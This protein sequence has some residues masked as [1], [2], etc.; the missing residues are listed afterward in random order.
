[1]NAYAGSGNAMVP[2]ADGPHAGKLGHFPKGTYPL[3]SVGLRNPSVP[4]R[5]EPFRDF[6]SVWHD[7]PAAAQ[8]FNGFFETDP[9]FRYVLSGVRDAFM[10]N[11][12]S[13]SIGPEII[14]NR[15]GVGPMHDCLSCAFE[16][17][18]LSSFTVG[19]PAQLTDVAANFGGLEN[20]LPGQTPPPGATG[21][22]ANFV[23]YPADP[24]N[25]HHSYT[26]DFV[27][28][29]NTHVGKEQHV[30]H[31]HNH[32]WLFNAN[33]DNSN[34]LDAQ[35][36]GP[37]VGYTYEIAFGGSGN[38]NKT[39]GDAIFHCHFYPHFAQGMWYLWRN[40][41]VLETG[42]R[43]AV[44]GGPDGFHSAPFALENGTPALA[45]NPTVAGARVRALPDGEVVAGAPIP[46]VVPLPGKPMA[47]LPGEVQTVP[48]PL[49]V[50]AGV[51]NMGEDADLNAAGVQVPVGSL[52]RVVEREVNPGYPFWIAGI[53]DT[54]GQRAT[55][56][57]LDMAGDAEVAAAKAADPV[58]FANLDP[59]QADGFDGGLPRATLQGVA[60]GGV[61]VT[62][63]GGVTRLDFSKV[64]EE[65]Q[66]VFFP[67]HGTDVERTAMAFHAQ[68]C[69]D[70][71]LP[72]GTPAV[73]TEDGI[74]DT[75][76]GATGGFIVNGQKPAIGAPYD[77][78]CID[79]Q[80]VRLS[81]GVVGKFFGAE[82][83][84]TRGR[85]V[86][87]AD[88]PRIYKGVSLQFDA[89][90]NKVGYHYPQ[91]RVFALWQDAVP[92][93]TKQQAPEPFVLRNNTFDCTVYHH[94][95]LIPEVYEVDD[96]QVRTPT[97]IVGQHVHLP[98][99]DL[100][101]A[102]GAANGWN[103][104]DGTLSPGMVRERIHALN[105]F[106]N[107][108]GGAHRTGQGAPQGFMVPA[109]FAAGNAEAKLHPF[110][111][112]TVEDVQ[113]GTWLGA[114]TTQQRWFFDPVVNTEGYDR[115]LGIIFTHDH[116][117]PSTHQQIGLYGTLLTEP[118]G[119]TWVHNETGEQLGQDP[120]TGAQRAGRF[121]GGPTSWQAA[122]LPP[123]DEPSGSSVQAASIEPFRE[124]FFEYADFQHAYE[125]GVY[126]GADQRGVATGDFDPETRETIV[127]VGDPADNA[128]NPDFSGM[129][130][131]A[132]RFSINP[133]GRE[134][135][136]PVF[137]D[138][139]LEAAGGILPGCPQRPCPQAIDV[140]DPGMFVV[141]YRNEPLGLRVFDP[142]RPDCPGEGGCQTLGDA[143]DLA[144]AFQSRRDR[145]I[146]ALNVQPGLGDTINGTRFPPALSVSADV[147][148]GDP[149]TPMARANVGDLVRFKQEAGAH[150]EEHTAMIHGVKWLQGGSGHGRAPNSGWR[151]AQA[152]GIAEQFTLEV[153]VITAV[154]ALDGDVDY[155]YSLD[156]AMDGYWS[157]A[158][159]ILRAYNQPRNDL[160]PLPNGLDLPVQ[161]ANGDEFAGICPRAATG[162]GNQREVANLRRYDVTA[163]LA[164]D[165]LPNVVTVN[166]ICDPTTASVD[167]GMNCAG[168][169]FLGRAPDPAGGTLVYNPRGDAV[170]GA[171]DASF[172]GPLHDPTAVLWFHT[173]DL[174]HDANGVPNG[175]Q[176][177]TPIEPLVVRAAAGDCIEVTVRN[178]LVR[179]QPDPETGEVSLVGKQMPS[180]P[181]LG[182]LIGVTKRNRFDERGATTFQTNLIETS[183]KVGLH[184]Q[185]VAFDIT[186]AD[187][188][189]VGTNAPGQT[190]VSP[191][192]TR[193]VRWYAGDVSSQHILS[194]GRVQ[195]KLVATPMELG[196]SNLMPA[197]RIRQGMKSLVGQLVIEPEGSAWIEGAGQP[198]QTRASADVG[199][200]ADADGVPDSISFRD[201]SLVWTKGLSHYYA[202]GTP[203][204]HINGEGIGI[205][206]DPQDN[207]HM[208]LNYLTDPV[209]FR[210]GMLPQS[211]F[212]VYGAQPQFDVFS[213]GRIGGIDPAAPVFLAN[214]EQATRLRI[215][216]P[217]GTNRGST[218]ELHGHLWQRDPY[219]CPGEARNGLPGACASEPFA[220]DGV[221]RTVGSRAIGNNPQG[222]YL[223][224]Q[225]SLWPAQHYEI[226]LPS[227]GGANA[228][229][230][231][232]T[233]RDVGSF[234][235][236]AGLWGILRVQ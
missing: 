47:P 157:G 86:F 104:E 212:S 98:K 208:A 187:G 126:V 58:L 160:F 11:Y 25:V 2:P 228:R 223:G 220:Q 83:L 175:L 213:N 89:V 20:L 153:P 97:D 1:V 134:E 218:F 94:A 71:F 203:V 202:D 234:G 75:G 235:S 52:T 54:V 163:V 115:G 144:L 9:V 139:V 219:V 45:P 156:T 198:K 69:H 178:G 80:G 101:S 106:V 154:N 169:G 22:K 105:A 151:N 3:E 117:D 141:N 129:P 110:F 63:P 127:G 221:T 4:N 236:A 73:C 34:Y 39:S 138:L 57:P 111:G 123:T 53:E 215:A 130:Q 33:D 64:V 231:D 205:P 16:E 87:T 37:G 19:D 194:G 99:W 40:H 132:F 65:A 70:G 183:N 233:L 12:G 74:P 149:F 142:D 162:R 77:E 35:G 145:A 5:L 92:V 102:D 118:A 67:E 173:A 15:L 51:G 136:N 133:P 227:A 216:S 135:V 82:G 17:F 61:A 112:G 56:P 30:Y 176:P 179:A 125:A 191:G 188:A 23:P 72:D 150:E 147:S 46:A 177:D 59:E 29:R 128:N 196:G 192:Q 230:G 44:S 229:P 49:L 184:P 181:T 214:A 167:D 152:G 170:S 200:D 88:N 43:L 226:T 90:L 224:A 26:G 100:T 195:A 79:D 116:F 122:V 108:L 222:M 42:T 31:L 55:T 14:A 50:D 225:E 81:D 119:S 155:L 206:E 109:E 7:E 8:A 78:P 84:T 186:R 62:P 21:P 232:Y 164:E 13:A 209:W 161:V 93:I 38:R 41:D 60:A 166:N 32:Q 201:F 148:G 76:P 113:N 197:D 96:Y 48:N 103:Y 28:F 121:D 6:A 36:I 172:S 131:A 158:W 180:L 66:A 24:A 159:G 190:L 199:P 217:H 68:R 91:Q 185:L 193:T 140:A 107:I 204:G 137:P 211:P 10:I 120:A 114:R 95:N 182:T 27:K 174:T 171:G 18:F 189:A 168:A 143:G 124:F 207:T 165:V 85:S 146:A 210:L